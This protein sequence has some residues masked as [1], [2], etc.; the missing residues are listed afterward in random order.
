M[1]HHEWDDEPVSQTP[2]YDEDLDVDIPE[3]PE[4]AAWWEY[5]DKRAAEDDVEG[6]ELVMSSD[7]ERLARYRRAE[8]VH[9]AGGVL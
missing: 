5:V 4:A 8:T 6:I 1:T 9:V 7:P 2:W 3:S